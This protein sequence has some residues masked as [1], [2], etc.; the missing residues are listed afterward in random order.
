MSPRQRAAAKRARE[1]AIIQEPSLGANVVSKAVEGVAGMAFWSACQTLH[2][3][4]YTVFLMEP[5]SLARM[6]LHKGVGGADYGRSI[7]EGLARLPTLYTS[8]TEVL[9]D[10]ASLFRRAATRPRAGSECS[11]FY[12]RWAS[13]I[14]MAQAVAADGRRKWKEVGSPTGLP[15]IPSSGALLSQYVDDCFQYLLRETARGREHVSGQV[16]LVARRSVAA[17]APLVESWKVAAGKAVEMIQEKL[18]E[19]KSSCSSPGEPSP[20]SEVLEGQW[21]EKLQHLVGASG[22]P[23]PACGSPPP[24][25]RYATLPQGGIGSRVGRA[26]DFG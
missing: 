13:A 24:P 12:T 5:E 23:R 20:T 22:K 18:E 6:F 10:L 14:A 15:S 1:E 26:I 3:L 11:K 9:V 8:T 7:Q 21:S 19:M 17:A 25:P 4:G 2:E 16:F